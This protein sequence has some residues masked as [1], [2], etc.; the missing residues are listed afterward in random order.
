MAARHC[1]VLGSPIEHS[2]SP[3]LHRAAYEALGLADWTY[4]AHRVEEGQLAGFVAGCGPEWVGLS[5]TMPLK[6][7]VLDLGTPSV[8]A[9]LVGAGNTL[10]F[11]HEQGRHRVENT[12]VTGMTAALVGAGVAGARR[13]L[14]VGAGATARSSLAA[15]APLGV[16]TVTVMARSAE[17]AH[18]SLDPVATHFG[19]RLLVIEWGTVPTAHHDVTIA[20]APTEFAPED[21][22]RIAAVSPVLFDV[23]Y[24]PWPTTLGAAAQAAGAVVLDG[25]DLLAHQA[26]G[27][28]KLFTGSDLDVTVLLSAG[29]AALAARRDQ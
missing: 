27:Q 11:D 28:V 16:G 12:D 13:A 14:L 10:L 20:T 9:A 3:V 22:A 6:R 1:A 18:A 23:I 15:L 8:T 7:V 25:V 21:A 26:V 5:L 2:L 29:R 17:R 4:D 24:D 19:I